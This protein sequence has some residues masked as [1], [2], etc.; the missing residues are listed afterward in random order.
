[1]CFST[2]NFKF[3]F[4]DSIATE[5][6]NLSDDMNCLGE[7]KVKILEKATVVRISWSKQGHLYLFLCP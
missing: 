1:M 5:Y 6:E 7:A 4:Q 3:I 2:S